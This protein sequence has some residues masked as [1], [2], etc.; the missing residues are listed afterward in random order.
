M[1]REAGTQHWDGT[2]SLPFQFNDGGRAAA[3]FRGRTG[4]C[5]TRSIAIASGL[6][7]AEVYA[8]MAQG[9]GDQRKSKGRTARNGVSVSRKWFKDYMLA[10]RFVWVPTMLIGSGCTVHLLSGE[11]PKGRLVVSLSKHYTAVIDGV[12]H[13]TFNPSRATITQ[14]PDGTQS[15]SHRCV[16]GY[17]KKV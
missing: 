13:D 5:V 6:P 14:N 8:A 12:I 7:Y 1:K 16:Y 15:M 11:L 10:A 2:A 4:D 9:M 3:G 17:W